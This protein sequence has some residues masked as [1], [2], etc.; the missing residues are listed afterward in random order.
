MAVT[1]EMPESTETGGAFLDK[2]GVFHL[3]VL[4]VSESPTK[5]NGE[6]IPNAAFSVEVDVLA[7][8][9][10]G[11]QKRVVF[12][13]PDP[14]KKG[15]KGYEMELRKQRR[16]CEAVSVA[17]EKTP[18]GSTYTVDMMKAKARQL[19]ME[20][21]FDTREGKE[22]NLQLHF[23]NIWH[24]DDPDESAKCERNQQAIAL[25]PKGVRRDPKTFAKPDAKSSNNGN[26]SA[27]TKA[28]PADK[29]AALLGDQTDDLDSV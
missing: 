22:K 10:K 20:F 27:S 21:Q 29:A 15:T 7:G 3:S 9:S 26:G 11:K 28:P 24:I 13:N 2:A 4:D 1:M 14:S 17:P 19:I 16:F 23:A 25:L 5:E 18:G 12:F 6:L 8:P